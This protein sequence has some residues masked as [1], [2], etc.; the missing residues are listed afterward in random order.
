M[1]QPFEKILQEFHA[2][3]GE[4]ISSYCSRFH[5]AIEP[6]KKMH[7]ESFFQMQQQRYAYTLKKG[8]ESI[9]GNL[10]DRYGHSSDSSMLHGTLS[11][12]VKAYINEFFLDTRLI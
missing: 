9:A 3:A 11:R 12:N 6:L 4:L 5:D 2:A 7:D 10:L 8:L 1:K